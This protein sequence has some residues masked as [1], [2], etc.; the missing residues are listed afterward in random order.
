MKNFSLKKDKKQTKQNMNLDYAHGQ[1][2]SEY[3]FS[4]RI[5]ATS[6][7]AGNKRHWLNVNADKIGFQF[8]KPGSLMST[9]EGKPLKLAY[10]FKCVY[11]TI[12]STESEVQ[13]CIGKT[14][15]A[16]YKLM[17]IWKSDLFPKLKQILFQAVDL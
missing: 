3:T 15:T 12:S 16:I 4:G 17:T 2:F 13:I 11:S 1:R 6:P 5:S 10:P 14:W 7:G 8:L 9:L